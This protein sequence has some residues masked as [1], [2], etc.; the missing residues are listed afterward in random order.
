MIHGLGFE[1]AGAQ[2]KT[3]IGERGAVLPVLAVL[4]AL[5]RPRRRFRDY[6]SAVPSSPHTG[7]CVSPLTRMISVK[8]CRSSRDTFSLPDGRYG[9]RF[10]SL[11]CLQ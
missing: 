6:G 5:S 8:L 4:V 11:S 1:A 3:C 7:H 2:G 10:N 9:A